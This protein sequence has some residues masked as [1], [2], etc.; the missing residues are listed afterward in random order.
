MNTDTNIKPVTTPVVWHGDAASRFAFVD[1]DGEAYTLRIVTAGIDILR[2]IEGDDCRI[3]QVDTEDEALAYISQ[4]AY[5][6]IND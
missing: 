6:L 3:A 1:H 5:Q 4:Y 2:D